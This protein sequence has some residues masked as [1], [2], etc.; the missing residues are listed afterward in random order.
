MTQGRP[1]EM[2]SPK[3]EEGY[4]PQYQAVLQYKD[5]LARSLAS[6]PDLHLLNQFKIR[7]WLGGEVDAT[8]TRL[9]DEALHRI[10]SDPSDYEVFIGMLPENVKPIVD[11]ITGMCPLSTPTAEVQGIRTAD[12][13]SLLNLAST[14]EVHGIRT[15]DLISLLSLDGVEDILPLLKTTGSYLREHG[16]ELQALEEEEKALQRAIL[17]AAAASGPDFSDILCQAIDLLTRV[18]QKLKQANPKWS[19]NGVNFTDGRGKTKQFY[20]PLMHACEEGHEDRVKLLLDKGA[21]VDFIAGQLKPKPNGKSKIIGS[22][23]NAVHVACVQGRTEVVQLLISSATNAARDVLNAKTKD[24]WTPLMYSV[25]EGHTEVVKLL[26]EQDSVDIL[27]TNKKGQTALH[28]A[29]LH[30]RLECF[31]LIH[32]NLAA[33]ILQRADI[34]NPYLSTDN[35]GYNVLHR[36]CK[37]P[38]GENDENVTVECLKWICESMPQLD[39]PELL[40]M[41]TQEGYSCL[42]LACDCNNRDLVEYLLRE[43]RVDV[44]ST[45]QDGK[46]GLHI[47]ALHDYPEIADLVMNAGISVATQDSEHK[48]GDSDEIVGM[49]TALHIAVRKSSASVE[50]LIRSRS[51][52]PP[53]IL[54]VQNKMGETPDEVKP[55]EIIPQEIRRLG[56]AAVNRYHQLLR[57][58]KKKKMPRCNLIALG[59]QRVGKTSLLCLLTGEKFVKDRDPTRGIHNEKVDVLASVTVS[60]ETWKEVKSEDIAKHNEKQFASSIA[61]DF[62]TDFAKDPTGG[63]HPPHPDELRGVIAAIEMHLQEIERAAEAFSEEPSTLVPRPK[64]AKRKSNDSFATAPKHPKHAAPLT[65]IDVRS[66]NTPTEDGKAVVTDKRRSPSKPKLPTPVEKGSQP[67][68]P[69]ERSA[70]P[71]HG[72]PTNRASSLQRAPNIGRNLTKT[73]VSGAKSGST[74]TESVL[75]YNTLDFAGQSEYRAMH[76]CFIVRRAIYL[77]V[78]NLLILR[79]A[80]KATTEVTQRALE[81]IRY[82]MNSIHAHIHKMGPE[83]LRRVMLVG[84]HRCPK[85]GSTEHPQAPV[86]DEEL[87][88]IDRTLEEMFTDTPVLND[89]FRTGETWIATV[90]NSLDGNQDREDSGAVTL[91]KAIADAW[92]E[93]P[94]KDEAYPTTWLRFEAYLQKLVGTQ[95]VNAT[96]IKKVAKE[97]FGIGEENEE[98]IEMALGFFHDTGTIVYPRKYQFLPGPERRMGYVGTVVT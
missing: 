53:D 73:I 55:E 45:T 13:I 20:S 11:Q 38:K 37:G 91:Q 24:K 26:L 59:E 56:D 2:S 52:L 35:K 6:G 36:V 1:L 28:L 22:R 62:R 66:E 81:E 34:E 82:W 83:A 78:F 75:R 95:I 85:E 96:I 64:R 93:L 77:V 7:G 29:G 4:S 48:R 65:D 58:G 21:K 88:E 18:Q 97:E 23:M 92:K 47:A 89:I 12:L 17:Q 74:A 68:P 98:D 76:H 57:R 42:L 25:K 14:T 15:A 31:K 9:I 41:K 5:E 33:E 60:S 87:R 61:E 86:T 51:D 16:E 46:T 72:S 8:P 71:V 84:T 27:A 10:Q 3:A 40:N 90:E 69:S 54:I 43:K 44:N 94:F 30:G 39:K 32:A 80:L 79:D 49:D 63:A 19:A 70:E 67:Q 50:G